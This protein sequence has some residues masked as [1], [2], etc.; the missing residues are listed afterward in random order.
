EVDGM[1]T[2]AGPPPTLSA[3]PSV[4]PTSATAPT[5]PSQP[6]LGDM[7]KSLPDSIQKSIAN[8]LQSPNYPATKQLDN[9]ITLL[10][11]RLAREIS[12]MQ[13]DLIHDPNTLAYLVQFD[14]G[15]YPSKESKNHMARVEF[16]LDGCND[17][18]VY[19]LYP[20]QSSYN[21][22][23]YQGSSKR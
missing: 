15:L 12:V 7:L 9:F 6:A 11:E 23:N 18:K 2:N 10:H 17:C 20:G 16:I 22:A 4:T 19:S 14:V 13:D 5:P 21:V 1:I 3:A 8:A